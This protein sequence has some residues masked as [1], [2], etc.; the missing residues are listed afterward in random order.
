MKKISFCIS[1]ALILAF[2]TGS[3]LAQSSGNFTYN[4][5]TLT[6]CTLNNNGSIS[7][8]EQCKMSCTIDASGVSTCVDATG[9][10]AGHA[11]AGIK[12]S[13]GNGNV[14]VVRPSAVIGLLTDVTVSSK[15]AGA[16][17]GGVSSSAL[18]GVN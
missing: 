14:F 15:Q 12:T 10:C 7:G 1:A 16:L 6:A 13:S 11:V 9:T 2:G 5:G 4:A 3:A 17:L 8:G 18:A